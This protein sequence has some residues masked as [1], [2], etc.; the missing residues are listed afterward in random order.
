MIEQ[1]FDIGDSIIHRFDP[2][3]KI[4]VACIFSVVVALS[5]RFS[6]VIPGVVFGSFLIYLAR[7]PFMPVFYR[8]LT[9]NGLIVLLWLF[10]PFTFEGKPLFSFGPLVATKEGVLYVSL[11]TL[12]ANAIIM[13]IVALVATISV[14]DVGRAMRRLHVPAKLV[15]L[16]LFTYRYVHVIYMEYQR[17]M[18]AIKIRGF[19]PQTNMHTYKT[20]AYLVGVL[21]IRSYDRAQRVHAAM[22]CRG[23]TE[24]FYDLSEFDFK[25]S[26]WILMICMLIAVMSLAFLHWIT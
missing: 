6:A 24:K 1:S 8:I 22:L 13:A 7:L 12:K 19:R 4:I 3:S 15:Q 11:I 26:D 16:F 5:D 20:Y 10:L 25:R 14:F 17:I 9:V 2:R 23:F 21:F 18:K